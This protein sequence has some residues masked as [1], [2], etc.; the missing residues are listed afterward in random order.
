MTCKGDFRLA[1]PYIRVLRF[2]GKLCGLGGKLVADVLGLSI[3]LI[4]KGRKTTCRLKKGF[5]YC[6][7]KWVIIRHKSTRVILQERGSFNF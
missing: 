6:L 3:D 1:A 5:I 2:S 7:E 4:F